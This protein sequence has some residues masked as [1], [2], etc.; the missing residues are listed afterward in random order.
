MRRTAKHTLLK[1][2][3]YIQ[4][5]PK[6]RKKNQKPNLYACG[7]I[8]KSIHVWPME[9]TLYVYAVHV[10]DK[11]HIHVSLLYICTVRCCLKQ[12]QRNNVF[13][14]W[15]THKMP[16]QE[17]TYIQRDVGTCHGPHRL[18]HRRVRSCHNVHTKC[19]RLAINVSNVCI[20]FAFHRRIR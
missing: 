1:T 3:A 7:Y 15:K 12:R 19:R 4:K 17:Y 6:G 10:H 11:M 9:M 18:T 8:S 20:Y 2:R 16:R 13:H 5:S 14:T